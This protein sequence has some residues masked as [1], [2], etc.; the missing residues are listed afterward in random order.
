MLGQLLSLPIF[1]KLTVQYWDKSDYPTKIEEED[2]MSLS[3]KGQEGFAR[4]NRQEGHY[5]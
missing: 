4:E 1:T 5:K 2:D 3:I